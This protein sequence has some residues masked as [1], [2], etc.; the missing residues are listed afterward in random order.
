MNDEQSNRTGV[1]SP[2]NEQMTKTVS[3]DQAPNLRLMSD[4][5][6]RKQVYTEFMDYLALH[7]TKGSQKTL[8]G[9]D[10]HEKEMAK[11]RALLNKIKKS[12][13]D[14]DEDWEPDV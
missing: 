9:S 10:N 8:P 2:S 5:R 11:R 13:E 14:G 6:R 1:S 12:E 4:H 7:V 3:Q